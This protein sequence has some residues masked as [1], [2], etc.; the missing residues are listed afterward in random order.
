MAK[1]R[2]L[3]VSHG[4][5]YPPY[6]GA[7]QRNHLLYASLCALGDVATVM[8]VEQRKAPS[9]EATKALRQSHN[10]IS[11]EQPLE[12]GETGA[13]GLV[14][15][16]GPRRVEYIARG[17]GD[18]DREYRAQPRL[19]K[20]FAEIIR[21]EGIDLVAGRY[22]NVLGKTGAVELAPTLLD[23]DDLQTEMIQRSIENHR[24]SGLPHML[25][26]R[27]LARLRRCLPLRFGQYAGR[28]VANS[29][30]LKFPGLEDATVLPNVPFASYER[31]DLDPA[32]SEAG[33][34]SLLFVGS[35]SHNPNVDGLERFIARSWPLVREAVPDARLVIV[36]SGNIEAVRRR[37][38]S[39]AGV[40]FRGLVEDMAEAYAGV[41]ASVVPIHDGSGTNIKVAESFYY[42]RLAIVTPFA[43][44]GYAPHLEDRSS[45]L[46]G[47]SD[48]GLASACVE[49]LR[50]DAMRTSLAQAGR[51]AVREHFSYLVF[52]DRVGEVARRGAPELFAS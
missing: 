33:N 22:A 18:P 12:M 17:V 19:R 35:M 3:F 31:P 48:E 20:R 2:I 36:G 47:G 24:T 11:I 38:G 13:F 8:M 37:T 4:L 42:G 44:R 21:S 15:R 52:R 26:K 45:I 27:R 14:H 28:W 30:H 5:P 23:V 40:E 49:A 34:R 25:Q 32:P 29:E 41:A 16:F 7:A 43:Q 9:D 51:V 50:D 1:P 39:P 10:L 46:V 6:K